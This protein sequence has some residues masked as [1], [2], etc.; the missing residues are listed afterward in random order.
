MIYI[1]IYKTC[2]RCRAI[3]TL[4]IDTYHETHPEDKQE[5]KQYREKHKEEKR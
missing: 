3:H 4:N 1:Y 2:A 5:L